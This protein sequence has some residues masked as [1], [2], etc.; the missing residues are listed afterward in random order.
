MPERVKQ[1][2]ANMSCRIESFSYHAPYSI[3]HWSKPARTHTRRHTQHPPKHTQG[4]VRK[5]LLLVH[6]ELCL[7]AITFISTCP[8]PSTCSI[9]SRHRLAPPLLSLNT[10]GTERL[11][12]GPGHVMGSCNSSEIPS[13]G[14]V[15]Y[16]GH[17]V[18]PPL[19]PPHRLL[20]ARAVCSSTW[21]HQPR[22]LLYLGH[23]R[24]SP[25]KEQ[26]ILFPDQ[27]LPDFF[28][29]PCQGDPL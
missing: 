5:A 28:F 8:A 9:H 29:L 17:I 21:L 27:S 1:T 23:D 15:K 13:P 19:V 18:Q 20:P 10:L 22:P 3:V 7:P 6:Y 12:G 16:S 11:C 2:Y 24:A 14:R 26:G 25:D 4:E